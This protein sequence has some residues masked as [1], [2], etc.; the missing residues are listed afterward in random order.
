[1]EMYEEAVRDLEHVYQQDKSRDNKR[2][3]DNAKV[4]YFSCDQIF[5]STSCYLYAKVCYF[6][7]KQ[8]SI[9]T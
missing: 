1:M 9:R 5:T 6:L 8:L 4:T 7:K 3:L 2:L